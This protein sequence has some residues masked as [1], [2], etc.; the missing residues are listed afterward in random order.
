[1]CMGGPS[2]PEKPFSRMFDAGVFF[3]WRVVGWL[4]GSQTLCLFIFVDKTYE[5]CYFCI[6]NHSEIGVILH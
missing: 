5:Y 1:M 4:W 2:D 6:I 3:G